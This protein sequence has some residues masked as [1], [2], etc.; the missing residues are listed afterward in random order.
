MLNVWPCYWG[1]GG[2][3]VYLSGDWCRAEVQLKL[4]ARTR[5]YMGTIFGGSLYGS[6]DPI[7]VLMLIKALG[8]KYV[9]W[10]KAASIRFIKPGRG[11]LQA[12]FELTEGELT[13]VREAAARGRS[14]DRVYRVELKDRQGDVCALIEKMLYIRQKNPGTKT[15]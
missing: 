3:V 15:I 8:P 2:R 10:D 13:A 6:V 7:Y 4:S 5:N 1:T 12:R 14:V 9:V 11:V